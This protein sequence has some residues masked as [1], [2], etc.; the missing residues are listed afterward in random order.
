MPFSL[1]KQTLP[2]ATESTT[3]R[4]SDDEHNIF[5]AAMSLTY[6]SCREHIAVLDASAL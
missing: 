1:T 5:C 6:A 3:R 2:S 4:I